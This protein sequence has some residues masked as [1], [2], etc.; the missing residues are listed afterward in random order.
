MGADTKCVA[1]LAGV[2]RRHHTPMHAPSLFPSLSS[3]ELSYSAGTSNIP[4]PI[5]FFVTPNLS[6][7]EIRNNKNVSLQCISSFL[8][9]STCILHTLTLDTVYL[10]GKCIL[11]LF[12]EIRALTLVDLLP[13][14]VTDAVLDALTNQSIRAPLLPRLEHFHLQ[15]SYIFRDSTLLTMIQS[16]AGGLLRTAH[17]VAKILSADII[18]R[19]QP[20]HFR[21]VSCLRELATVDVTV[22]VG[23]FLGVT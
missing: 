20:M 15:G 17:D 16:R 18:L 7:L 5:Y 8:S 4:T 10:P 12:S 9:R 6:S 13:N 21:V 11:Q 3:L 22:C 2:P 1:E 23:E 14:A 19:H